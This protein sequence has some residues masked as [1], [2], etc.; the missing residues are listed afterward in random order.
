MELNNITNDTLSL[1]LNIEEVIDY[2]EENI[3]EKSKNSTNFK[4]IH[5]SKYV[6][7]KGIFNILK[8]FF[9]RPSRVLLSLYIVK[10][11]Q[12]YLISCSNNI[13]IESLSN[14]LG[15]KI[16]PNLIGQ[17]FIWK[18]EQDNRSISR[19]TTVGNSELNSNK[20]IHLT[21][22]YKYHDELWNDSDNKKIIMK[23]NTNLP[24]S[25][26]RDFPP[27]S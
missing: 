24:A 12:Y 17:H 5:I 1:L 14:H 15:T 9:T 21:A 7:Q 25:N 10:T 27:L 2:H 18:L 11:K 13:C 8:T 20:T 23:D 26:L 3:K 4:T 16:F 6:G 19:L 22:E